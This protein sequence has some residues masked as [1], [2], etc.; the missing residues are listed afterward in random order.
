MRHPLIA[1]LMLVAASSPI[2]GAVAAPDGDAASALAAAEADVAVAESRQALWT[3]ARE[4]LL[5]ARAAHA[6]GDGE[7]VLK[8]SAEARALARLGLEQAGVNDALPGE[9]APVR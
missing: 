9:T 2:I 8:W 1:L 4:A 7:G 3:T 6:R 5:R